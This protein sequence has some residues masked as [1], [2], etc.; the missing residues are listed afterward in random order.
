MILKLQR[1][2]STSS[3][4]VP[5]FV[6]GFKACTCAL[7][8]FIQIWQAGESQTGETFQRGKKES[9]RVVRLVNISKALSKKLQISVAKLTKY[10]TLSG[11]VPHLC[12]CHSVY[13]KMYTQLQCMGVVCAL[14]PDSKN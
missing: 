11:Q 2:S 13:A 8:V 5:F 12:V 7:S 4:V 14:V 6:C 1:Q 10:A 9:G 3:K